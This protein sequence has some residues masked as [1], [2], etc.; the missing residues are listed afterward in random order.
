M[1]PEVIAWATAH[2]RRGEVYQHTIL[3]VGSADI[4]GS[5]RPWLEHFSPRSYIGTDIAPGPGVDLVLPAEQLTY[6]F[7]ERRFDLVVSTEML[8]H[9]EHWRDAVWNMMAVTAPGGLMIVTTRSPGFP[10]HDWP[11]D[12]WRFTIEDFFWIWA[13]WD[14]Q[15]LDSDPQLPGVFLRVR[16]PDGWDPDFARAR[17]DR[18]TVIA[19]P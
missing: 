13:G 15:R 8:E 1:T 11:S 9:A 5:L 6:H 19:A 12:H 17:L 3:E 4:N 10:R 7:G 16:K 18:L 2:I 14:I